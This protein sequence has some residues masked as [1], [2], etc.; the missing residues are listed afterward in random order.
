MK[1]LEQDYRSKYGGI[2]TDYLQRILD[3]MGNIKLTKKLQNFVV[4][5]MTRIQSIQW[6]TV[7]FVIYLVPK[8]C[9]R[10]RHNFSRNIFYV[11]GAKDNRDIFQEAFSSAN[12]E[13]I[14]MPCKFTCISYLPIPSSM[15][16]G[17]V[18]LAEAGLIRPCPKPDWDNLGKT[19]S[20]M[21]QGSL[22]LDDALIIEG[23]SKKFYS[24]KPRIEVTIEYMTDFDSKYN[25]NKI[26]KKVSCD[27]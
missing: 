22:L 17:E 20:D 11:S 10:P 15:S 8:A 23:V 4:E 3:Y 24:L 1:K 18:L 27:E 6:K 26:R 14:N 12:I 25:A 16:T 2:S 21:I 13:K 7:R 9:P 19:Y 5:E